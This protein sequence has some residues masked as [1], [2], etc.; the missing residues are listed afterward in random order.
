[1]CCRIPVDF[2]AYKCTHKLCIT[3][4]TLKQTFGAQK[5]M[6]DNIF[7]TIIYWRL[8]F[9]TFDYVVGCVA[10]ICYIYDPCYYRGC[11][12]PGIFTNVTGNAFG[13]LD[14][15]RIFFPLIYCWGNIINILR[16]VVSHCGRHGFHFCWH[17][18]I[19]NVKFALPKS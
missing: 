19:L 16:R 2:I 7:L 14:I 18:K 8:F 13:K 6:P 17:F 12:E 4:I 9:Q 3:I 15:F 5:S 11:D 1:M 10:W